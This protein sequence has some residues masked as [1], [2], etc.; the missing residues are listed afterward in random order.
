MMDK[1]FS[2][3]RAAVDFAVKHVLRGKDVDTQIILGPVVREPL[4]MSD[5]HFCDSVYRS[6]RFSRIVTSDAFRLLLL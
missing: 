1:H 2:K 4:G 5:A 3:T 6:E